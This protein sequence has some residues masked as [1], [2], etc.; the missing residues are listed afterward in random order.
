MKMREWLARSVADGIGTR[1]LPS[2][3]AEAFA[4]DYAD[5]SPLIC[6]HD[7]MIHDLRTYGVLLYGERVF[8]REGGAMDQRAE[9]VADQER[10]TTLRWVNVH[11]PVGVWMPSKID[12]SLSPVDQ[13]RRL[14]AGTGYVVARE[15][16]PTFDGLDRWCDGWNAACEAMRG[17]E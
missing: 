9:A 4:R 16:K 13:A 5:L 6:D 15:I 12:A 14:L 8:F 3:D 17:D 1:W 7:A 2:A 11:P 10:R